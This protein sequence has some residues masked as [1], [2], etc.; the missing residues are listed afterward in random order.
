MRVLLTALL[1]APFALS[2][3]A[4]GQS[5]I[6]PLQTAP[7][8]GPYPSVTYVALGGDDGFPALDSV[9]VVIY[10]E[11][12]CSGEKILRPP[13]GQQVGWTAETGRKVDLWGG[14]WLPRPQES[15]ATLYLTTNLTSAHPVLRVDP[16]ADAFNRLLVFL[17]RDGSSENCAIY[18]AE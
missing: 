5:G 10:H 11:P 6:L 7:S 15:P 3:C 16:E 8:A 1:F 12:M 18:T 4:G 17:H 2:A 14:A 9:H 13:Y